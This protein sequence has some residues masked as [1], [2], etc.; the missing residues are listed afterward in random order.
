MLAQRGKFGLRI[1]DLALRNHTCDAR[2]AVE[3]LLGNH[4]LAVH[5]GA[6][7]LHRSEIGIRNRRRQQSASTSPACDLLSGN[8]MPLRRLRSAHP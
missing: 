6:Q 2:Q 1:V 7:L 8:E 4:Q 5:L 3:L